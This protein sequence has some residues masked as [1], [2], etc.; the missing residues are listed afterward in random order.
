MVNDFVEEITFSSDYDLVA[1]TALTPQ[2][3]RAYQISQK[4][5]EMGVKVVIGGMHPTV[6]P[7][8]VLQHSDAVVVGEAENIWAQV[9]LDAENG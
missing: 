8:E 1:I 7:Q 6:L 4:F 2:I 3:D 5:R 9:L